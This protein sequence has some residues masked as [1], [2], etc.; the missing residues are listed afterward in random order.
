MGEKKEK[1][2]SEHTAIVHPPTKPAPKKGSR[3]TRVLKLMLF[4]GKY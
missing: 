2:Q 1:P 4:S 3:V